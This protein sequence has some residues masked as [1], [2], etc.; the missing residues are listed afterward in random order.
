MFFLR[1]LPEKA[2]LLKMM[3]LLVVLAGLYLIGFTG[4]YKMSTRTADEVPETKLIRKLRPVLSALLLGGV[5][6]VWPAMIMW[7]LMGEAA[8]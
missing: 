6:L 3:I 2:V 8:K 4:Y 1:T 5:A 7:S